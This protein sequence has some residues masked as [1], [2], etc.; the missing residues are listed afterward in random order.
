MNIPEYV[1][2]KYEEQRPEEFKNPK[3]IGDNQALIN[4]QEVLDCIENYL[5][6]DGE[7]LTPEK[8]KAL[9][10]YLDIEDRQRWLGRQFFLFL[11]HP[12]D[13]IYGYDQEILPDDLEIF[14]DWISGIDQGPMLKPT[15]IKLT[16]GGSLRVR[17]KRKL[18]SRTKRFRK[19]KKNSRKNNRL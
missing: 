17:R 3:T 4:G 16:I 12:T 11:G 13:I 18:N 5:Y 14:G 7:K 2:S 15:P 10:A 6:L 1:H 19:S 9:I 8:K